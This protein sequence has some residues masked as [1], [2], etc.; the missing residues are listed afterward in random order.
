MQLKC[1]L[2]IEKHTC[3]R[4]WWKEGLFGF[5][6]RFRVIDTTEREQVEERKEEN[7]DAKWVHTVK[8]KERK[9]DF[10]LLLPVFLQL[11]LSW[12]YSLCYYYSSCCCCCSCSFSFFLFSFTCKS[13]KKKKCKISEKNKTK[14]KTT[15]WNVDIG[16][17]H[18][19]G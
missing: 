6:G 10:L 18:P 4:L 2:S 15:T 1:H 5:F 14:T 19:L 17:V 9:I 11:V 12:F 16:N 7:L 8:R 3:R 13:I